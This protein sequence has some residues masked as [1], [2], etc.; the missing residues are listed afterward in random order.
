MN[1]LGQ[2]LIAFLLSGLFV[3]PTFATAPCGST[4][5]GQGH[6]FFFMFSAVLSALS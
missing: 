1:A 5:L 6:G 2:D 4:C 3:R